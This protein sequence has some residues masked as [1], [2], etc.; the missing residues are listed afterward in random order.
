M[1]IDAK[2]ASA[3]LG[4]REIFSPS[5]V[6]LAALIGYLAWL[7]LSLV[8]HGER[9]AA[10]E[11]AIKTNAEGIERLERGQERLQDELDEIR[12]ILLR[13]RDGG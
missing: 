11:V 8:D 1:G 5:G 6:I 10:L 2:N 9:L 13:E 3:S 4:W 12:S 7:G